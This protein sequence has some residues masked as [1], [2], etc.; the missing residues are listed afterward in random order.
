MRRLG[1]A[2]ESRVLAEVTAAAD[3]GRPC[4]TNSELAD[5]IG[6]SVSGPVRV[7]D[8]LA[9][10][11]L[12]RIERFAAGRRVTIVATGRSTTFDGSTA[13]HWRENAPSVLAEA[14]PKLLTAPRLAELIRKT[15][16][17]RSLSLTEFLRPL[18]ITGSLVG[19]L[20]L[21]KLP[22]PATI[23][24]LAPVLGDALDA[25]DLPP[26]PAVAPEP[27]QP[28]PRPIEAA[29][30]PDPAPLTRI[31]AHARPGAK[32][33]PRPRGRPRT[34]EE[35]LAAVAAGAGLIEVAPLKRR[36]DPD[37]TLGGVGSGWL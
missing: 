16:A 36:A 22:K 27:M 31:L 2:A 26:L 8:R 3:A 18:G 34:F 13:P 24:R 9:A 33:P 28:K 10:R 29:A 7:L 6:G 5:L 11:A 12:I 17:E 30:A 1:E 32:I 20:Q 35:Q 21:A 25:F 19:N 4:P 14:P 23:A 15:A 37:R